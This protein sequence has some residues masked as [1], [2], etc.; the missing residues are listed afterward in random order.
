VGYDPTFYRGS[1]SH[2]LSGRPPYSRELLP[3]LSAAL[4]LDGSG[5][6]LDVGCGPGVL[7]VDLAPGF[8]SVTAI[9]PDEAMLDEARC[10]SAACRRASIRWKQATGEDIPQLGLDPV[11]VATFGQ[12][13]W[14]MNR[15][16]VAESV[17]DLLV[18]G[19]AIVLIAHDINHGEGPLDTADPPIPHEEIEAIIAR[20]LGPQKRAGVGLRG[21]PARRSQ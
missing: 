14:W 20:Y 18:P 17:Y 11:R 9:D 10:Y 1:A 13:L 4:E 16:P 7:A 15:E 21:Q 8:G 2:Y 12:S 5:Q 3:V 19:G 6:L